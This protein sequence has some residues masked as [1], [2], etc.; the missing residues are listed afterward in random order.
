MGKSTPAGLVFSP[1]GRARFARRARFM[2]PRERARINRRVVRDRIG[3]DRI[4]RPIDL[5]AT[6]PL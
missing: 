2:A 3:S 5:A 4:D 6:P 1:F